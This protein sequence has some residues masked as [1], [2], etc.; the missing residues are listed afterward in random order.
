ML[1]LQKIHEAHDLLSAMANRCSDMCLDKVGW[2]S[3]GDKH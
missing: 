1:P 2:F 3:L